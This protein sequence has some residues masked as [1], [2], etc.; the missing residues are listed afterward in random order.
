MSSLGEPRS[1]T[2]QNSNV[3]EDEGAY[4]VGNFD[5]ANGD[6]QAHLLVVKSDADTIQLAGDAA[7]DVLGPIEDRAFDRDIRPADETETYD[8]GDIV[9][10]GAGGYRLLQASEAI[11][12]GDLV[13]PAANGQVRSYVDQTQTGPDDPAAVVGRAAEAAAAAGDLLVVNM[14]E[15]R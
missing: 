6:E 11:A 9:R 7:R 2:N 13:V 12:D 3:V 14:N 8:A 10:V 1:R 15:G 4:T 5:C